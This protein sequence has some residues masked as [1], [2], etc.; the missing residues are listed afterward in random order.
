MACGLIKKA[1]PMLHAAAFGVR[2]AKINAAQAG[3]IV[4]KGEGARLWL[5]DKPTDTLVGQAQALR[6]GE[7][8]PALDATPVDQFL[9][10]AINQ[11]AEMGE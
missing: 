6:N 1:R 4:S 2:G 3:Q 5:E 10:S 9:A 8:A 7:P 11:I